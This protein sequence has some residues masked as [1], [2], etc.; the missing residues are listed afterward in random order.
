MHFPDGRLNVI[1]IGSVAANHGEQALRVSCAADLF[2]EEKQFNIVGVGE[3]IDDVVRK[4]I[5]VAQAIKE[6]SDRN[7][8]D[9]GK[10]R[11]PSHRYAALVNL[12]LVNL[13]GRDAAMQGELL[14]AE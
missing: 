3:Q 1:L 6:P 8:E 9:V 10:L 7:A 11:K 4:V 5:V 13:L 2:Q 14:L 12:V